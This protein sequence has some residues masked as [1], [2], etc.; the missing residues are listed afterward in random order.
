MAFTCTCHLPSCY[1]WQHLLTPYVTRLVRSILFLRLCP[2][3]ICFSGVTAEFI[4]FLF[5]VWSYFVFCLYHSWFPSLYQLFSLKAL[6]SLQRLCQY[7]CIICTL[8][9]VCTIVWISLYGCSNDS[10]FSRFSFFCCKISLMW[11][12]ILNYSPSLM[13]TTETLSNYSK[14]K[15]KCP[16]WIWPFVWIRNEI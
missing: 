8:N 12:E 16:L 7:T 4:I 13:L 2:Y 3:S 5:C 11:A 6:Y 9:S 14:S 15:L 1:T 10:T